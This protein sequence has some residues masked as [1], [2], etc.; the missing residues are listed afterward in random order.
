MQKPSVLLVATMDTKS[1]EFLA[2]YFRADVKELEVILSQ[3]TG[4]L[5]L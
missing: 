1:R 2:K 5:D 3:K 4:W